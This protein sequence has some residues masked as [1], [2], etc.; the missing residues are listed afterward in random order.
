MNDQFTLQ[1]AAL[2]PS[3]AR[4]MALELQ[5]AEREQALAAMKGELQQLQSRYLREIGSLYPQLASLQ[6]AVEAAE[7]RA[8]IRPPRVDDDDEDAPGEA[9]AD[10]K[11]EP[12]GCA[13]RTAPSADLRRMFRD[14]AK[15]VHP[16]RAH[17][18]SAR[19]RR[20]SL[21]AEA[22]RAYAE[23]DEDRLRLILSTWHRSPD[24]II[25]DDPESQRVRTERKIAEID[26]RLGAIEMEWAD[27]RL[28][29]I[30]RLKQK[31]DATR[32][33]G[34]DLFAEMVKQVRAEIARATAR[35]I[36]LE[37]RGR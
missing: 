14:V 4:L 12:L 37:R 22:N 3:R 2:E 31:I 29:A 8:G 25:G 17:D 1:P 15:A 34:W 5:L 21:M 9:G 32:A 33:Q 23:R 13:P 36:A 26:D 16:D 6:A 20:H 28:S 19:F 18:D 27:L 10:G 24:A 11:A 35:L 30:W 7:I